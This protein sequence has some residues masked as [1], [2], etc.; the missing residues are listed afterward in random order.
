MRGKHLM[1]FLLVGILCMCLFAIVFRHAQGFYVDLET[2]SEFELRI[3]KS[4][5][6]N[7]ILFINDSLRH[8]LIINQETKYDLH[9]VTQPPCDLIKMNDTIWVIRSD[10]TK[11][12]FD[13]STWEDD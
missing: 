10:S 7:G 1:M 9:D 13:K 4:F 6:M 11:Y 8:D 3:E 5:L 2:R 12:W